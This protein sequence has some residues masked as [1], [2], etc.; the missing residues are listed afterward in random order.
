MKKAILEVQEIA[1][2]LLELDRGKISSINPENMSIGDVLNYI[3]VKK[4]DSV[5]VIVNG[6]AKTI[7]Y[8]INEGDRIDIFPLFESG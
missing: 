3:G 4:Y 1:I 7:D 2:S 8:I 5:I 6:K